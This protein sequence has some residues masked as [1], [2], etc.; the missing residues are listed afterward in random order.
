MRAELAEDIEYCCFV[1]YL[2]FTQWQALK[3]YAARRGVA[4]IG[5]M[6]IYVAMDS[7]DTWANPAIFQLDPER[8]PLRVAGCPPDPF[9]EAG[10]LWGNPLYDWDAIARS[11]YAWWLSRLR[12]AFVLYDTVRIDHF[13]GFESY[14]SID[15]AARDARSGHW[16]RGPGIDF[17][18]TVKKS[19]PG[20]KI[21]AEDLGYLTDEVR[22]LL[23]ASGFPGMKVLQFAFDSREPGASAY[24]PHNYPKNSVVYTGT[25]DNDTSRGWFST[26]RPEDA[27]TA[28]LYFG[29]D[30]DARDGSL[31]CIRTALASAA[32]LAII[33]MQDWLGLGSAA[34]MNTPSTL[35]GSNW[36]WRIKPGAA[37]PALAAQIRRLTQI[38]GRT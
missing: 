26:A 20:A 38:T 37:A 2:A 10:Q 21:I 9:A 36:Q 12:E 1:Q 29:L 14:Y 28:R 24:M 33:P 16:V 15:A 30:A 4:I 22:A 32:N 35:G 3:Q 13:R 27:E 31:A 34:R 23:A 18:D 6:P 8:R 5:D 7:A 19:I 11:G 25:H 17:I